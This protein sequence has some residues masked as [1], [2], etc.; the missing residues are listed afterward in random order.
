MSVS[1]MVVDDEPDVGDLFRQQFRRETRD[2]TYVIHFVY[3]HHKT[4][5]KGK[6]FSHRLS[7]MSHHRCYP[8][9]NGFYIL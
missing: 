4:E 2:G 9:L 3:R 6:Q 1:I 5:P 8:L 7:S